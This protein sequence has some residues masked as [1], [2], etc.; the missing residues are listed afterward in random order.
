MWVITGGF[1]SE[2]THARRQLPKGPG[3]W[4]QGWDGDTGLSSPAPTPHCADCH[5]VSRLHL[6]HEHP[7]LAGKAL[8]SNSPFR[9]P[10]LRWAETE[11]EVLKTECASES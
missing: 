9:Q 3:G 10:G 1:S 7:T 5:V 6:L 11:A 2:S 4:E 8:K